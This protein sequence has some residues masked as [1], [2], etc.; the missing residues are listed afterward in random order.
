MALKDWDYTRVRAAIAAFKP[1]MLVLETS[2]PL[3]R[4]ILQVAR[5]AKQHLNCR[6]V[7]VGPHLAAYHDDLLKEPFVDHAVVGEYEKPLL[8]IARNEGRAKRLYTYDHIEN[9]D[10]IDGDNWLPYRPMDYLYNYWDQSMYTARTQLQVNTWRGCPFK[11]TYC[12]WPKVMNNGVYRSH[13]AAVVLDEIKTVIRQVREF[14]TGGGPFTACCSRQ[15]SM[16]RAAR[17]RS[18]RPSATMPT[19]FFRRANAMPLAAMIRAACR[20]SSS[21]TT[22]GTSAPSASAKCARA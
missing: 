7:L 17:L 3:V 14:L 19:G 22:P 20:A 18:R 16:N 1:D 15:V 5:W 4:A 6:I 13:S 2:T 9:I 10:T 8:D 21:T 12:Q 11:C